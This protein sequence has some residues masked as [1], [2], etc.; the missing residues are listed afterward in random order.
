MSSDA[1]GGL[2]IECLCKLPARVQGMY[3]G[4]LRD[5]QGI[6]KG[7][8]RDHVRATTVATLSQQCRNTVASRS[9]QALRTSPHSRMRYRVRVN[10]VRHMNSDCS[11]IEPGQPRSSGE[12]IIHCNH[13]AQASRRAKARSQAA[14]TFC[15]AWLHELSPRL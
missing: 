11:T 9:R 13:R 5:T 15:C 10:I 12:N 8:P 14:A 3:K 7:Y 4:Y 6:P 2:A 1:G